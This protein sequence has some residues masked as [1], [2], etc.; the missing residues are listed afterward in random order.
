[1]YWVNGINKLTHDSNEEGEESASDETRVVNWD[2]I[3][4]ERTLKKQRVFLMS[5]A[6]SR[7]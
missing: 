7:N 5:Y 4:D 2:Q 1:M 3:I 6:N